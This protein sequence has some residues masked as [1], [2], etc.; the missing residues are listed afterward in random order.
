MSITSKNKKPITL[1]AIRNNNLSSESF[2]LK[3]KE[4]GLD[5]EE[6]IISVTKASA[7]NIDTV[8]QQNC[9]SNALHLAVSD[10]LYEACSS[11]IIS[12]DSS[13]DSDSEMIVYSHISKFKPNIREIVDEVRR[14]VKYF[15]GNTFAKNVLQDFMIEV[16]GEDIPLMLNSKKN[17]STLEPMFNVCAKVYDCFCGALEKLNQPKL[18][19]QKEVIEDIEISLKAIIL[20][21]TALNKNDANLLTAEGIFEFLLESLSEK[22]SSYS[23]AFKDAITRRIQ[24][25]KNDNLVELMR[26]L[27]NGVSPEDPPT[28]ERCISLAHEYIKRLFPEDDSQELQED[29][30]SYVELIESNVSED[31]G[32]IDPLERK[33]KAAINNSIR[34]SVSS[35]AKVTTFQK[36]QRDFYVLEQSG[37]LSNQLSRLLEALTTIQPSCTENQRAFK[38]PSHLR[39]IKSCNLGLELLNIRTF[40]KGFFESDS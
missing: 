20:S 34:R 17:W 1:G 13:S 22:K 18:N 35:P 26:Y 29:S 7:I 10:V 3:L 5:L 21:I 6:K 33:L 25:C 37:K 9:Y 11:P 28:R 16:H 38:I 36:L 27:Q 31:D 30:K 23:F 12:N 14:I 4:F 19:V 40:L 39:S 24:E 32:T 8:H 2:H 15:S